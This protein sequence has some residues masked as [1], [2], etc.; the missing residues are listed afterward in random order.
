[1]E[2]MKAC[3]PLLLPLLYIAAFL[4]RSGATLVSA[5]LAAG[6]TRVSAF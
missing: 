5:F 3:G 2:E 1:M 6:F 4:V